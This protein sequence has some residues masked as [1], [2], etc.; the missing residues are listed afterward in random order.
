MLQLAPSLV[1][2]TDRVHSLISETVIRATWIPLLFRSCSAPTIAQSTLEVAVLEIS[3][4]Q[5]ATV[6]R[7]T[8][9][10]TRAATR[11]AASG[12]E[13]S[14]SLPPVELRTMVTIAAEG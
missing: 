11:L 3:R 4:S 14:H 6:L 2:H 5:I 7:A 9:P 10:S 8:V 1:R 13:E 12:V